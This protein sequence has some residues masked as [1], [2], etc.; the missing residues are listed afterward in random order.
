MVGA[1]RVFAALRRND[2]VRTT[3]RGGAEE[4]NKHGRQTEGTHAARCGFFTFALQGLLI[5]VVIPAILK[6]AVGAFAF[7]VPGHYLHLPFPL[8]LYDTIISENF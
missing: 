6:T 2:A 3:S 5:F 4:E 8:I 1:G 7:T